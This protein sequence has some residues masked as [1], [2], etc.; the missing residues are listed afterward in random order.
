MADVDIKGKVFFGLVKKSGIN[1]LENMYNVGGEPEYELYL[2]NDTDYPVALKK[3]SSGGFKT[4]DNDITV[5]ETPQDNDVDITIEPHGY[6]LYNELYA[7]SFDGARQIEAII[8]IEDN[9][10]RLMFYTSRGVGFLGTLLPC[11]DNK[12]G[13]VIN[14]IIKDI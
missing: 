8:E 1:P 2:V 3:K 4:Y 7:D 14:P 12:Y 10:K 13:R 9:T 5:M 6:I 11:L